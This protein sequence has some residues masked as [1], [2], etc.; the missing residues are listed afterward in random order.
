[1]SIST[2]MTT[3]VSGMQAQTLRVSTAA[4]NIANAS[5]PGYARLST[6]LSSGPNGQVSASVTQATTTGRDGDND[7][8]VAGEMTDLIGASESFKAN[9]AVFE[10]GATIWDVLA[11]IKR[12]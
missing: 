5:H 7:V 8:D 6:Q 10:T 2:A 4:N 3:A 11:T 1:M 12:D 9:A